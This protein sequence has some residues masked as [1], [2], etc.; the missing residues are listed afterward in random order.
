[1]SELI[2]PLLLIPLHC[3]PFNTS[4]LPQ[5]HSSHLTYFIVQKECLLERKH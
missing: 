1:M 2:Y 5:T 4:Q 3:P